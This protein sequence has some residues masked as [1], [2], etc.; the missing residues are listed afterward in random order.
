MAILNLTLVSVNAGNDDTICKGA[1]VLL[2]ASGGLTYAWSPTTGLNNPNISNPAASPD[3]T[4]TYVV[5]SQIQTN[6][7]IINGDFSQGNTGFTSSYNYAFPNLLEGQYY[8]GPN[9]QLWNPGMAS[10]G[11][12]STGTGKMLLIN[13]ATAANVPVYC[14]TVT[15]QPNTNYAFSTWLVSFTVPVSQLQFS[16]NGVLVG[17]IF[18]GS[19]TLCDW[20]RFYYVW[21]SGN[22]STATICIVNQ[23][24]SASGNDF[25]L[26]DISFSELCSSTDSVT[27]T[28]NPVSSSST[29]VSV[30]P[31]TLPY[32]WNGASYTQS[33]S[34][35]KTG[36]I[37]AVGCDSTAILNLT[38]KN[39]STSFTSISTC[40]SYSWNGQAYTQ[41]GS[42]S[43][44]GMLNSA[45]CDSTAI[46]NL[47]IFNSDTSVTNTAQCNNYSWNGILYTQSG[48]YTKTGLLNS[49]GCD[50]VAILSLVILNSDTSITNTTQCYNYTWNGNTYSQSGSYTKT[51]LTNSAGCDSVAI[52]NLTIKDSSNSFASATSCNNYFW[53]GT[54]YSSSGSYTR[55]GF[56]NIAGCDSSAVLNLTINHSD[57]TSTTLSAC[58]S[59]NWNGNTFTQ[60]G[61]YSYLYLNGF[62]CPSTDTLHLT[63]SDGIPIAQSIEACNSY[64]WNGTSFTQSGDYSYTISLGT[65]TVTD[66]L[67]LTIHNGNFNAMTEEACNNY[68]WNGN[69][70]TQSGTYTYDYSNSYGCASA[71]TLH[72]TIHSGNFNS[73]SHTACDSYDWNG[74]SYTQSGIYSFNYSNNYGCVSTDTLRLTI[75][76]GTFN[77]VTQSACRSYMWNNNTYINSG[78]Y[79]NNYVNS[80]GC[81]SADSLYLT[82]FPGPTLGPDQNVSICFGE[83]TDLTGLFN[84]LLYNTLW[85]FNQVTIA[86]PQNVSEPGNYYLIATDNNGCKDSAMVSLSVQ[87]PVN[88][89]AGPD[90]YEQTNAPFTLYGSGGSSCLWSPA[91]AL[92]DP[93]SCN[94]QA[95]ISANT[96][97]VLTVFDALG[98]PDTDTVLIR[99]LD[100]PAVYVPNAFT[101]NGDGLNDE[102]GPITVGLR[103][104]EYFRIYNRYGE[105]VFETSMPSDKWNGYFKGKLQDTG[106][107]VWVAA[108]KDRDGIAIFKKGNVTLIR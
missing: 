33:G 35:T 55:S 16:I 75:N 73:I 44:T 25:G 91:A 6:N 62:G 49:G 47:I 36:L 104:F 86:P 43:K 26:D 60:S 79:W 87:P 21:N 54:N 97:F 50:S 64:T 66:T 80:S 72:L 32:S 61:I 85:S 9:A 95:T 102:F 69:S 96:Q 94:P 78:T 90:R 57:F 52:L 41:S 22:S 71:D 74:N 42:Y 19:S 37:N 17:S 65:C 106:N 1:S 76:Y 20:R 28:V 103:D 70:Y 56:I 98:C 89:N 101:P 81:A 105:L 30:C 15:I 39:S 29:Q 31:N 67:H 93:S 27:I 5:T 92:N 10:C 14:Q 40:N 46:L 108:A 59:Y 88:A 12:H 58:N 24:T 68:T 13:G 100:G 11:D 82:I 8:V 107:F 45:G 23:N 51:G 34:Y 7:L 2:N 77:A 53:N 83:T 38:V 63:V 48:S 3:T 99:V 84:T 4:T 18:S